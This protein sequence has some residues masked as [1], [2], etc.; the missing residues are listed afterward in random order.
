M[1]DNININ[2]NNLIFQMATLIEQVKQLQHEVGK[3]K[4]A[5]DTKFITKEEFDSYKT[6]F[7]ITVSASIGSVISAI[8]MLF[9]RK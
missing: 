6:F 9:T 2:E 5:L 4:D 1:S 3:L 8:F 7:W